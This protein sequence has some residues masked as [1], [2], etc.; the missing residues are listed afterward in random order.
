VI[1]SEIYKYRLLL[2]LTQQELADKLNISKAYVSQL[3]N[4]KRTPSLALFVHIVIILD[5]CP[6]KL[7]NLQ[8]CRYKP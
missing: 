6:C 5:T 2:G 1:T 8:H 7:L 4:G 3:E